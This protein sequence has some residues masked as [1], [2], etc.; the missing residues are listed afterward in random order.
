MVEE[1]KCFVH[2]WI[3][4]LS[5]EWIVWDGLW[6]CAKILLRV[7]IGQHLILNCPLLSSCCAQS[8]VLSGTCKVAECEYTHTYARRWLI[9]QSLEHFGRPWAWP[10]HFFCATRSDPRES[11]SPPV[12]RP[13]GPDSFLSFPVATGLTQSRPRRLYYNEGHW[14]NIPAVTFLSFPHCVEWMIYM[15]NLQRSTGIRE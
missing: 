4:N 15:Y 7:K 2:H 3:L 14:Y 12:S 13:S 1:F 10:M 5:D 9:S 11:F 8:V 6:I